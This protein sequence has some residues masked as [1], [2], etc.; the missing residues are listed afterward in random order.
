MRGTYCAVL[1]LLTLSQNV[2]ADEGKLIG[3]AG[4]N[5]IEGAGGGGLVPWATLSGYDSQEQTSL[6]VFATNV[7]VDDYRL[8]V[9]GSSVSL[10]DRVEVSAA[11]HTFDLTSLGGEIRQNIYGAKVR[12]YGDVVYSQYPQL[13][14]GVQY[15]D[16]QDDTIANA[17]GST[18]SSG[19]DYYLSATKVHLGA[20]AGY[21]LVWNVTARMTKAN[22]LGLLGFGHATQ[23]NHELMMEGSVGILFNRHLAVGAEY[24]QKPDNL[25]LGEDDWWDVFVTYIPSKS[26]NVTLAWAELGSIA[27]AQGQDGLYLSIGGQ[28]W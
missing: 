4:L 3:T 6:N 18:D 7:N 24:R 21:N 8:Q 2:I 1:A 20:A 15:K 25:G 5:Q 14:A 26:F 10:Y 16:L 12:L 22:Q 27:G 9:L 13:S 11:R 23:D 19:L 17:L 28:L